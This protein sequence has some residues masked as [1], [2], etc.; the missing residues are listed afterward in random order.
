MALLEQVGHVLGARSAVVAAIPLAAPG[1][2]SIDI[3]RD[4]MDLPPDGFQIADCRES[5]ALPVLESIIECVAIVRTLA[6][7]LPGLAAVPG[8]AQLG[9]AGYPKPLSPAT[10]RLRSGRRKLL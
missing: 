5:S 3:D 6:Q 1:G 10:H 8:E 7:P 9:I 4:F 2:E